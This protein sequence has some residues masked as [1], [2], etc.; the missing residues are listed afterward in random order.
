M[1]AFPKWERFPLWQL[2]L[3][4]RHKN[5]HFQA[6]YDNG[7]FCGLVYY[8]VGSQTVYLLYLAVNPNLRGQGYGTQILQHL[9]AEFPDKQLT[10]DIEPVTKAAKNYSQRVRRLHFYERNGFHQ[11]SAKLMD[12]DGEFQILTTGKK[13]NTA[14]VIATLKQMSSGFYHFKV[15]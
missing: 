4:A 9:Q 6:L 14:S 11:T 1:S 12:A 7:K 2:N 8:T 10:L 5:V 3:M 13:L 15:E